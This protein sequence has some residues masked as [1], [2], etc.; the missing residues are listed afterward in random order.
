MKQNHN[1]IGTSTLPRKPEGGHLVESDKQ[2][3]CMRQA[4]KKNLTRQIQFMIN[5]CVNCGLCAESCHYSCAHDGTELIPANKL[6]ELS[7]VLQKYFHPFKSLL[8]GVKDNEPPNDKIIT[9]LYQAAFQNCT[10]CGKCALTCPMGINTGEIMYLARAM[11]FSIGHV[12]SGLVQPVDNA[13]EVGNYLGISTEDFVENIEWIAEEMSEEIGDENFSIPIDKKN[14]DVLYIPHPLEVR[15]LPFLLMYAI[16]I[17]HF[18]NEDYTI[19]SHGFDTV[20]YAYYQ[21]NKNNMMEISKRVLDARE[22]LQA[23]RI[24]LAPCGHGYRVLRWEVESYQ[25]QAF[26]FPPVLTIVELIDRYIRKGRIKLEKDKFEG[27]ITYHDPCNLARRG[28]VLREPRN[29]MNALTSNYVEMHPYGARNYCCGGGGGLA[30]TG[31]F[32]KIRIKAGKQKAEQIRQTGAKI[33]ATNCFNCG[34]QIRDLGKAYNLD[35]EVKSIV[36]LTAES[37]II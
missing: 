13:F 3:A 32:G 37:M 35:I 14:A 12:P 24:A 31:D 23:K 16:K 30:S 11:L 6:R 25:G 9:K 5:S 27:P 26:S 10:I 29:V 28:G 22:I 17:L 36:E 15:D 18:A 33:V 20:N 21:G 19:S 7:G 34:T 4:L 8:P 2:F 1:Q